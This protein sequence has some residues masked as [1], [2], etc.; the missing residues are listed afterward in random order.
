M[1]PGH[2]L[3]ANEKTAGL[4]NDGKVCIIGEEKAEGGADNARQTNCSV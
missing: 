4:H 3:S 2:D 1:Q